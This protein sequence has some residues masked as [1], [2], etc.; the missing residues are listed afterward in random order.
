MSLEDF[1]QDARLKVLLDRYRHPRPVTGERPRVVPLLLS[2]DDYELFDRLLPILKREWGY[3]DLGEIIIRAV[4][5]A[6]ER[7]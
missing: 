4:V 7:T 6:A 2:R 1:A 5:E 3:D